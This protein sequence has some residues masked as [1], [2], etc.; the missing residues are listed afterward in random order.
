[1]LCGKFETQ[2]A[3]GINDDNFE[4]VAD[5]RHK[6]GN[7]LDETINRNFISGLKKQIQEMKKTTKWWAG[8]LEVW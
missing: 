2:R 5:F 6:T 7:L 8:P 3:D 4:F 1:M